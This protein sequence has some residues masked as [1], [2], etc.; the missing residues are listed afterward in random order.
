MKVGLGIWSSLPATLIL[1]G[2]LL[3]LGVL[4]Y[5]RTTSPK[6]RVGVWSFWGFVVFVVVLYLANVFG[7]PPP[8]A[9]AIGYAGLAAWLFVPWGYWIDRH[10]QTIEA[11]QP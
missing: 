11:V 1:E 6:D 3:I 5:L 8:S 4:L 9:E 2:G 10:R 7:P